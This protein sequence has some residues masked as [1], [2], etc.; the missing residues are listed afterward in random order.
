MRRVGRQAPSAL[1]SIVSYDENPYKFAPITAVIRGDCQLS[2]VYVCIAPKKGGAEI[3]C[4]VAGVVPDRNWAHVNSVDYAPTDDSIVVYSATA[5][6]DFDLSTGAMKG[7]PNP[8]IEEFKWG[9]TEPAV[10]IQLKNTSGYQAMPRT[11]LTSARERS[12]TPV[13]EPL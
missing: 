7:L 10:E 6:S 5:G 13:R 3:A 9:S 2:D 11:Q 8:Y 4:D 1:P 12:C